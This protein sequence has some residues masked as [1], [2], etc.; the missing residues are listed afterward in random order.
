M[1]APSKL[2]TEAYRAIQAAN[3]KIYGVPT[4]P[5]MQ[6]GATDMAFLRARGMQCYGTGPLVDEEDGPK[7]FGPHSDQ[8]RLLEEGLYKFMQF[9]WETVTELGAGKR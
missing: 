7:G 2:D 8:E 5:E 1:A 4:A 3:Q 9:T 6:T